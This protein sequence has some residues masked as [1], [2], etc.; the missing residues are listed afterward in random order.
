M[1]PAALLNSAIQANNE[2][3]RGRAID[4]CTVGLNAEPDPEL[5]AAFR[6][7]RAE[8]QAALGQWDGVRT[9]CERIAEEL[10]ST[11]TR[12]LFARCLIEQNE[13][14]R[15]QAL[16]ETVIAE[17]VGCREAVALLIDQYS[18]SGAHDRA[19]Q[20]ARDS[21]SSCPVPEHFH[22][23]LRALAAARRVEEIV[24]RV[25]ALAEADRDVEVWT[26]LGYAHSAM[27]RSAQAVTAFEAALRLAPDCRNARQGLG[28]ALLRE[29]QFN[30]GFAEHEFRQNESGRLH[31][32]G[33]APWCG[34]DL[35]GKH[36]MVWSEQ[37]L[38]DTIQFARYVLLARRLAR[39]TTFHVP[40]NLLRVFGNTP[41]LGPVVSEHPGFGT[42]DYQA[43]VMSLPH[44]LQL[45][46]ALDTAPVP[47]LFAEADR[48]REWQARLPS[49]PKVALAWQGN[50][51]FAGEPWRSM[52]LEFLGPLVTRLAARYRFVTLQKG[53]GREQI[54]GCGFADRLYDL[55]AEI[56]SGGDAFV[57][58]LAILSQVDCLVTTDTSLAH[59][60]G[61]AN[62]RTW[63]LLPRVADW[64]W[65]IEGE[66]TIWYPSM[67]LIRQPTD[68]NWPAVVERLCFAFE[69]KC[70]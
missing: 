50:P 7:E 49:E 43:L 67:T 62:V 46:E 59:L 23:L 40:R 53:H 33:I 68:G 38:G 9:D 19:I 24:E 36:L 31:R 5:E 41:D 27:G 60:A 21:F 11:R 58:S 28:Y 65:G 4:L 35:S 69:S 14:L 18:N 20:L 70:T 12:L 25:E 57:D 32:F 22:G 56:D 37:G 8:A 52:P 44:C 48:V 51:Q 17:D 47:Y 3:R 63:L 39:Q 16:L 66:R 26:N 10:R 15:A 42:A 1:S 55:G 29:G 30:R 6:L 54:P 61:A 34:E 45:G 64:R 2:G 13:S